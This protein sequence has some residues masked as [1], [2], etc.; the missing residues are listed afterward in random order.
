MVNCTSR[1]ALADLSGRWAAET[2]LKAHQAD[3]SK[4]QQWH[5]RSTQ[6][7][8][9]ET[10]RDTEASVN[11]RMKAKEQAASSPERRVKTR[12]ELGTIKDPETVQ[13][14]SREKFQDLL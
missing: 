1:K 11:P 3:P 7:R 13:R 12:P 5:Q 9:T 10:Y 8:V 4:M 6:I 2:L 14:I